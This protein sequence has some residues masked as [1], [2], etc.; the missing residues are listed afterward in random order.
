MSADL[1]TEITLPGITTLEPPE[2]GSTVGTYTCGGCAS[3]WRG[4]S[5][6]HCAGCHRTFGGLGMFDAHRR[7]V[8]GKGTCLD[9]EALGLH[10]VSD[11]WQSSDTPRGNADALAAHREARA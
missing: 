3:R 5:R 10:L 8:K 7:D 9:P 4:V 1:S 6:C 11:V 2:S